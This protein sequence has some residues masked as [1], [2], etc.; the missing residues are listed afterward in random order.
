M[1]AGLTGFLP[2]GCSLRRYHDVAAAARVLF[3]GLWRQ[4][5][6][7][8]VRRD[9][10][11]LTAAGILLML[12]ISGCAQ[13]TSFSGMFGNRQRSPA[14]G[15]LRQLARE[16]E[17]RGEL[18][19]ALLYWKAA[20]NLAPADQQAANQV[21][22][23]ETICKRLAEHHYQNGLRFY[24]RD[25]MAHARY[26]LLQVLRYDPDQAQALNLIK[27]ITSKRVTSFY[28]VQPGDTLAKIAKTHY[29]DPAKDCLIT[30]FNHLKPRTEL[31]PG[32]LI[33]LPLLEDM[34]LQPLVDVDKQLRQ[35][36]LLYDRGQY[37]KVRAVTEKILREDPTNQQALD[38]KNSATFRIAERLRRAESYLDALSMY[39]AVD[40]SYPGVQEAMADVTEILRRKAETFYL[41]GVGYFV[42]EELE[43]AIESWEKALILNPDHPKAESDIQNARRLLE[44]L[45][46]VN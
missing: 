24:R 33:E 39:K 4:S 34:Q 7:R 20:G 3:F 8:C 27:S 18:R 11:A 46:Q 32:T 22:V 15:Q 13:N 37:E 30:Y 5:L 16:A 14:A 19:T 2:S 17:R 28:L 41:M 25:E 31:D 35:A 10:W 26:E 1:A 12:F 44:K 38:L 45:K 43:F 29:Q 6:S 36:K 9:G 42:S 23:L 40:P 21:V